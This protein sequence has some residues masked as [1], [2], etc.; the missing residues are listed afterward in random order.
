MDQLTSPPDL[1][2]ASLSD[3]L[4]LQTGYVD[5]I[6]KFKGRLAAVKDELGAR[7]GESAKHALAQKQKE[8]GTGKLPLQDGF[9]AEYKI[10]REVKWDSDKLMAVAQTLPWERVQALFKIVFSMPEAIY[11]GVSA[12][13]PELRAKIDEARTTKIKPATITLTKEGPLA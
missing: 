9:V 11:A 6:D 12:L 13:S 1:G 5:A 7:Y 3:L 2:R 4:Q 8:H 10:D